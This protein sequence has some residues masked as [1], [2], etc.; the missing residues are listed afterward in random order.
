MSLLDT[1]LFEPCRL[2][3]WVAVRTDGISG[4]GTQSDPY[5][6]STSTKFDALMD[7]F[8]ANTA[9]FLGPGTFETKGH[10][11]GVSGGWQAKSG[12]RIMGSGIDVTIL[13][14][15]GGSTTDAAYHAVGCVYSN[16][17]DGFEAS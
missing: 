11:D 14:I 17:L 5:D 3:V 16:F 7:G 6:G 8:A 4:S 12:Q 1:F 10:G 13:K 9:I 2:N 15:V